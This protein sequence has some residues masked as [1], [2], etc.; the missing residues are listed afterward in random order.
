MFIDSHAHI[1]A[2]QFKDAWQHVMAEARQAG[3]S[4]VINN[5]GDL[6]SSAWGIKQSEQIEGLYATAGIHPEIFLESDKAVTNDDFARLHDLAKSSEKVVAVGEIGL[7]YTL[8][9]DKAPK[10]K[11]LDLLQ[12]QLELATELQ[13]PVTLHVRDLP[14]S[15]DCFTDLLTALRNQITTGNKKHRNLR[16]VVHCWV[17]TPDQAVQILDL[18]FYLSFSGILTYK[19]AGHIVEVAEMVPAD[20]MLIETDAPYLTPEPGRSKLR[21]SVNEPKYVIM[22][23]E[24]L[25]NI[26]NVAVPEIAHATAE[27][28]RRLFNLPH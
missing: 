4:T 13:L 27:N 16:G 3:V 19:T 9:A 2:E 6:K 10:Q 23:A 22:T 17:G 8:D 21:P 1:N 12:P 25:A 26:R 20:K 24:K 7:D 28:T 5:A 11:Q 15:E 18:G 14:G